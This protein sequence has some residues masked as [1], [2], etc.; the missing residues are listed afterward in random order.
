MRKVAAICAHELGHLTESKG[1]RI[2]RSVG[3]LMFMPWLFFKPLVYTFGMR[4]FLDC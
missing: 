2:R 1:T 4:A 3:S